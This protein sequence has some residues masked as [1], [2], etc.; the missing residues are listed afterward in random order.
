MGIVSVGT[1][2]GT[3]WAG[4]LNAVDLYFDFARKTLQQRVIYR[5]DVAMRMVSHA[6]GL[7][8]QVSVW[9]VL[10]VTRVTTDGVTLEDVVSYAILGTLISALTRSYIEYRIA[11]RV[12]EGSIANDLLRPVNF[13]YYMICEEAGDSSLLSF[14]TALPACIFGVLYWG[15]RV[16]ESPLTLLLFAATLTGGIVVVTQLNYVLGLL[17]FWFKTSYHVDWLFGAMRTVFSGGLVPLWFYPPTLRLVSEAFPWQLA[18]F[19]PLSV[20][21]EKVPATSA[22]KILLLQALWLAILLAI[23]G[24]LWRKAQDKIEVYGG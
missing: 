2:Q 3:G 20:F 4:V 22:I 10:F 12:Q 11:D 23:E 9:Q 19:A 1:G 13:K 21:L 16:P 8:V 18:S 15:M 24:V 7:F 5:T 17:S 14:I 6:L